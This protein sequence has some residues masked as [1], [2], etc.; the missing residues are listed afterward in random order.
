VRPLLDDDSG[1]PSAVTRDYLLELDDDGGAPLLNV[2]GG[3]ITAYR[4]LAEEAADLLRGP[5]QFTHAHWTQDAPLPGGDLSRWAG[6]ATRPDA[7]FA[8]FEEALLHQHTAL[9]FAMLRRWA[10]AY[11]ARCARLLDAPLGA[12]VAPLLFEAELHML[13]DEEWARCADD[14]LWRRTK[15][16][17]HYSAAERDAVAQWCAAHWG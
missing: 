11:G 2:W 16:G 3:K 9:P 14:V 17:L 10:R 1:D 13:H 6:P 12:E 7:D 5:L 8:R 4:R 15:L